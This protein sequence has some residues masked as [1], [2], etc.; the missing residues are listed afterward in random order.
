MLKKIL[1]I[2]LLEPTLYKINMPVCFLE[3]FTQIVFNN[4]LK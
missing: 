4:S 1:Q 3:D 2:A